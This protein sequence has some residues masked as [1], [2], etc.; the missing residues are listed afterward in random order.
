MGSGDMMVRNLDKRVELVTPVDDPAPKRELAAI[1]ETQLADTALAWELRA[2]GT[3]SKV[4]PGPGEEPYNS[5][6]ALMER[7]AA[8]ASHDGGA[9]GA[10]PAIVAT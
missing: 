6:T 2:D 4:E 9:S 8:R 5:Q 7:A 3:W 10:G 1:L